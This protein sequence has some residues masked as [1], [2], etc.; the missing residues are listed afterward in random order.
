MVFSKLALL[1]CNC[2]GREDDI[3]LMVT[4]LNA[5]GSIKEGG[6]DPETAG[7]SSSRIDAGKCCCVCL[8]QMEVGDCLR[9]LPCMH[10]FHELCI[11][12]WLEGYGKTC[13]LCRFS[14]GED[15]K[16]EEEQQLTVEMLIWFSSFHVAGF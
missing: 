5:L 1:L 3:F 8:S 10:K 9:M 13:P 15:K 2:I 4:A 14:M 6:F 12:R 16:P 7:S 11:T